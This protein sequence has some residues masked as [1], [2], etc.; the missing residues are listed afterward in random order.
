MAIATL[1]S[2]IAGFVRILV[3]A[4]AL[5]LG[6]RLLDTYNIANTLPN[7]VYEL[8]V[9][10]T[11]ASIV[12]PLLTRAALREPDG[13]VLYAQRLLTLI[14]YILS[15]LTL[16][17][18]AAAP[19]L[20]DL[21]AP[22][23]TT[24][25]RELAI[26]FSRYF[27]PQILFY[28]IS[29]TAAA[30]LN[31]RGHFGAPAWAPLCN[32]VIVIAVGLAYAAVGGSTTTTLET[33]HLLL[34]SLGTTAGV[35][36]QM[37][38]V[39]WA[40][41]RA[42]FPVRLRLDPRGIG[43]RRIGELGAWVLLSVVA[44]QILVAAATRAA[45]WSG[46]GGITAYQ[47]ANAI[48]HVPFAVVAVSVMTAMLPR[49]SQYAARGEQQR[50]VTGLSRAVR[51]ALVVM[52]PIATAFI[53]LGPRI[54]TVLFDHGN[55]SAAT[56]RVLG[57]V[58]A[59]YGLTLVPFTSYMI[60]QRG[61]YALQDTRTSALI[62]AVVAGVGV[63]GC[64]V[65][66]WLLQPGDI[67][68]GIPVAYAVAYTTGLSLTAVVLRRRLGYIDGKRLIRTHIRVFA[69]ALSGAV[70]A[71]LAVWALAPAVDASAWAGALV[72]GVAAGFAG[73]AGY[74]GAGRLLRLAELRHLLNAALPGVRT[75]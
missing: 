34:L 10:G 55:S 58:L 53:L 47:Y 29:A 50:V 44:T 21:Y 30:V 32:S 22:G 17:A 52:A 48:F 41:R 5:G 9:G 57:L 46:L 69:A 4:A 60:L 70:C 7:A 15:A 56:V 36:A 31:I 64:A 61:L 45:S 62:T 71:G 3:L 28:G 24:D 42:G 72:T 26:V 67:V 73:A 33:G 1:A 2:R 74:L 49:L 54:A 51:T 18:I 38:L 6:T 27:L 12:V 68:I 13:G 19:L 8:I 37:V 65:A 35:L 75:W 14:V 66:G 16:V 59:A 25:Q 20:I 39:V 11:M 43:I 63:A 40:L 23:F